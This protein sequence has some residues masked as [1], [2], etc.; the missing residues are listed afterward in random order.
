MLSAADRETTL[1][2]R[3]KVEQAIEAVCGRLGIRIRRVEHCRDLLSVV[4]PLTA[5]E[6][7]FLERL[8]DR[9][10]IVPDLLTSDAGV[11]STIASHPGLRWK[12]LN[13]RKHRGLGT[14]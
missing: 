5:T 9:G 8:N 11:Q 14:D 4:L 2:E 12:A 1:A 3:P 13:V 7:E 10:E 6:I